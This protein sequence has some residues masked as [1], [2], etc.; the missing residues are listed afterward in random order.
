MDKLKVEELMI[1]VGEMATVNENEA[2]GSAIEGLAQVLDEFKSGKRRSRTLLVV[3]DND[4]IVGKIT[5]TDILRSLEP[6]YALLLDKEIS[7]QVSKFSYLIDAMREGVQQ[8]TAHPW[9]DMCLRIKGR[10]IKE[11]IKKPPPSQIIQVGE[12]MDEAVHRFVLAKH[13]ALFVT[14]GKYFVGL[15]G[16]SAVYEEIAKRVKGDC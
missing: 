9:T 16:L 13:D 3:D 14:D 1:P 12:T 7:T 2:L 15:L 10:Q 6:R 5:P 11:F 8:Q 4:N